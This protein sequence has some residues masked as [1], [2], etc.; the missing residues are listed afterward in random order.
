MRRPTLQDPH[1][2]AVF[3]D[4]ENLLHPFLE[5]DAVE[6]GLRRLR[7]L[8]EGLAT[9]GTLVTCVAVCNFRLARLVAVQLS[10]IGFMVRTFTHFGGQDAADLALIDR[11]HND[12]PPSC[13]T[14]VIGSGDGIFTSVAEELTRA[15]RQVQAIGVPGHTS[16]ALRM[17]ASMFHR[18]SPILAPKEA[19]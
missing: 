8:L 11:I 13:G 17:I 5:L 7:L 16:A 9:Q 3:L 14:V 6:E 4:L 18:L 12:L 19:A 1:R 2:I 15:G 10:G